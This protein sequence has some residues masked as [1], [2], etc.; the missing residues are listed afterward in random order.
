MAEAEVI[1]T[2]EEGVV[3]LQEKH[4]PATEE[5][6][7]RVFYTA[8]GKQE[9][10]S[11]SVTRPLLQ[12][13][14][15]DGRDENHKAADTQA[16]TDGADPKTSV[17]QELELTGRDEP[18]CSGSVR[19]LCSNSSR[20][21]CPICSELFDSH[22]DHRVTLLNCNHALC[23]HCVAGI[24]RRAK[25]QSR[26]QCPFCRQT[27]P[28]PQWEIRRLQEESYSS[29]VYEPGPAHVISHSPELEE[30]VP[31]SAL[32]CLV[33]DTYTNTCG[34]CVD[35]S[36]LVRGLGLMRPQSLCFS[37]TA[38]LLLFL[39]LLGCFLYMVVPVIMVA[40]LFGN[41]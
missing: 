13:K 40:I 30:A 34:C 6:S 37:L 21:E 14:H 11:D 24:M 29:S 39:V 33:V 32:C 3:T 2:E 1:E 35:P 5:T 28:F 41:S 4:L 20:H 38:L 9:D 22:G 16:A 25:D 10:E 36:C 15:Q 19:S 31:A 12:Q 7:V 17:P 18:G 26:M 27:T 23:H 8:R